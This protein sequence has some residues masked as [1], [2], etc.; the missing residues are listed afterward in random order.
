M[1]KIAVIKKNNFEFDSL[2]YDDITT[3]KFSKIIKE[4]IILQ[5]IDATTNDTIMKEIIDNLNFDPDK[6]CRTH[7]FYE[8]PE[9]SFY[10]LYVNATTEQEND[11]T[12]GRY[13][14]QNH[15]PINGNCVI[16]K[17]NKT[18]I[19]DISYNEITTIFRSRFYHK[20]VLISPSNEMK[21]VVYFNNPIE[22]TNM[23]EQKSR[24][25]HIE[26][27]NRILCVFLE[28]EPS[29]D[30]YNYYATILC[31]RLKVHGVVVVS[32]M[33]NY[34][35]QE[36]IDL[37]PEILK[38]I[39]V[40]RSNTSTD[41]VAGLSNEVM[42]D[43]FFDVLKKYTEKYEHRIN[44]GIPDDVKNNVTLNSTLYA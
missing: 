1:V 26:F 34:P 29:I 24:C 22:N 41:N 7:K 40:V 35:S 14:S 11:N 28:F 18:A 36:I 6:V 10:L 19:H 32:M 3:D 2:T 5:E 39:L 20:A 17:S 43:N 25:I 4:N 30:Y 13:I 16:L 37:T 8:I 31:K 27:L 23:T 44:D 33:I 9:F 42:E 15:E 38:N 21:E 12:F